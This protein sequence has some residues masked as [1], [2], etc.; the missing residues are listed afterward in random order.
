MREVQYAHHAEDQGQPGGNHEQQQSVD[1]AVHERE[2]DLIHGSGTQPGRFILQLDCAG[3]EASWALSS[4]TGVKPSSVRS[5]LCRAWRDTVDTTIGSCAWWS[6]ARMLISPI[7]VA[8]RA[9][10]ID[11][12]RSLTLSAPSL[13]WVRLSASATI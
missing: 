9:V 13:G 1:D 7:G 11:C 2:K 3:V 8:M 10:S 6:A 4:N 12:A 5:T